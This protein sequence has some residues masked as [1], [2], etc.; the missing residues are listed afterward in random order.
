MHFRVQG[1]SGVEKYAGTILKSSGSGVTAQS[2]YPTV[3]DTNGPYGMRM[4]VDGTGVT[5]TST[6]FGGHVSISYLFSP[7]YEGS[8]TI[9]AYMEGY[10]STYGIVYVNDNQPSRNNAISTITLME[11]VA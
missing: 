6:R 8:V 7:A 9:T 2:F 4:Q 1:G 11:V 3:A 5:S 10:T